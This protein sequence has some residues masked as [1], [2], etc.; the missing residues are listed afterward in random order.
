MLLATSSDPFLGAFAQGAKAVM[1]T[2]ARF[3]QTGS[4]AAA[5]PEHTSSPMK[6]NRLNFIWEIIASR[7]RDSAPAEHK[8][9]AKTQHVP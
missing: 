3:T 9:S 4:A 2:L 7:L 8:I 1:R 6:I 5:H